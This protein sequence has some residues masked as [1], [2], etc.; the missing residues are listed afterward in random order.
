MHAV[1]RRVYAPLNDLNNP[2][3]TNLL[4]TKTGSLPA[5]LI[6]LYTPGMGVSLW[7]D[8]PSPKTTARQEVPCTRT[9]SVDNGYYQKYEPKASRRSRL[10]CAGAISHPYK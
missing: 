2:L 5:G 3:V 9:Y 4:K 1:E 10:N 6:Y 7:G 8:L